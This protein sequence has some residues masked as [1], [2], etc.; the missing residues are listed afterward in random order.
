MITPT[1]PSRQPKR[2]AWSRER[3]QR[4]RAIA[5][6]QAIDNSTWNTYG[7]AL[8]SYLSF[9]RNHDFPVDP[10]PNTLSFFTVYM[11]HHI[12]PKSVDSYL[13]GICHQLE[14]YFPEVRKARSSTLVQRTL[15]GCMRLRGQ[16]PSRKR[17]LT[18]DDLGTVIS[19]Y[20][21]STAH[22]DLLFLTIITT[23]FFALMRLGELSFPDN[24]AL[25][26][27]R[28]VTKCSSVELTTNYYS[29]FLPTDK[30]DH[31]FEGHKII[32]MAKQVRHNPLL[33]FT[34]YLR[35]RDLAFP[36][37]S[38]LWLTSAGQVPT[39][40]FFIRRLRLF[41]KNDVAGQS[42]RAGGATSLAENGAPPSIIQGMGRW[43]S[44]TFNIYVR[45]SPV[46][47]HAL[48]LARTISEDTYNHSP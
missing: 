11:C 5:L 6:G 15:Q 37:A 7:S 19:H 20:C 9:V 41:F 18:L 43:S 3:L 2:V 21:T 22:D 34:N 28:K 27:W 48:I 35:A 44:E 47:I 13:S 29:F 30:A 40:S 36:L 23:G 46:L 10:T 39:R 31:I 45:K 8:N 32:V 24:I 16:P 1:I 33:L 12:K 38:P 14:P 25:R 26:D 17:A 42:M 4:E